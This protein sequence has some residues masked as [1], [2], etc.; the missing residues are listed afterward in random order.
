MLPGMRLIDGAWNIRRRGKNSVVILPLIIIVHNCQCQ[1][2]HYNNYLYSRMYNLNIN[3][4]SFHILKNKK[5]L[6]VTGSAFCCQR[7]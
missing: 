5:I 2:N 4:N 1:I 3:V 7:Q 6:L